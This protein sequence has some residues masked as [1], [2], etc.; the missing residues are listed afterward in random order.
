MNRRNLTQ[1]LLFAAVAA[2]LGWLLVNYNRSIVPDSVAGDLFGVDS[3]AIFPGQLVAILLVFLACHEYFTMLATLF[4]RNGFWLVYLWLG[5]QVASNLLPGSTLGFLDLFGRYELFGLLLLVVA[6]A[7]IWG[8]HSSR[9]QR[10]SLLF[11]GIGFV[12]Y[13]TVSLLGYYRPPLQLIFPSYSSPLVGQMGIVT[14]LA[15]VFLCD[16]AAYFAGNAWGRHHFSSISPNKT[17]E[18][19]V[20]GL[21]TAMAVSTLGWFFFAANQYPFYWG[22][23][24]GLLIG[25]AGQAGDLLVS[26]I[27]RYF[28][29]KD[30]S[31]IIPGHGGI[32]DRFDSVFFT[33]PILHL[34]FI[35][36]SRL[37][38]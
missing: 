4:T 23:V 14:V 11:M 7:A 6:E 15:S 17:V 19:A 20:A 8:R 33:A 36:V 9:W 30:A 10:A 1:R 37:H 25:V 12:Y 16:T 13:A 31:N 32:L 34:F 24:M 27:K 38:V 26:L 2:P 35:I 3:L 18:G 22:I 29:V 21:A 28:R 5:L